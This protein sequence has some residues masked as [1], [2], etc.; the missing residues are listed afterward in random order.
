MLILKRIANVPLRW[1]DG[2]VVHAVEG[3]ENDYSVLLR[4][5]CRKMVAAGAV[6]RHDATVTCPACLNRLERQS[7]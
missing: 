6:L 2:T 3:V 4:T 1:D 5:S 7:K